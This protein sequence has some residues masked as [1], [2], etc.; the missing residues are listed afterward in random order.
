MS[1][2]NLTVCS[3]GPIPKNAIH[4]FVQDLPV[5]DL[6]YAVEDTED[7]AKRKQKLRGNVCFVTI[8]YVGEIKGHD[9]L[10]EAIKI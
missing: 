7:H 4:K 8:G 2:R 6:L 1:R 9:I 5:K 3:V 10:I